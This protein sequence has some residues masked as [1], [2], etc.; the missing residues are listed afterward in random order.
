MGVPEFDASSIEILE[1]LKAVRKRPDIYFG[2]PENR[3]NSITFGAM[4]MALA[5]G[6]C[7]SA[8]RVD[9][10]VDGRSI[11]VTDDGIGPSVA[12]D[13]RYDVPTAQIIMTVIGACADSKDRVE[14]RHELC[15]ASIAAINAVSEHARLEVRSE[16][17]MAV[18][19]YRHGTPQAAFA[20]VK[21]PSLTR[22]TRVEFHLDHNIIDVKTIDETVIRD[23]VADLSDLQATVNI[24]IGK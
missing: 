15:A 1:G 22:G 21:D 11:V 24:S 3:M 6:V 2:S 19:E 8:C 14:L 18:Q 20:T 5:E 10:V 12:I 23:L 16:G 13:P 9:L 17:S 4:C 7:G